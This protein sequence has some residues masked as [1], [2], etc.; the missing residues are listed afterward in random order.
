MYLHCVLTLLALFDIPVS[1]CLQCFTCQNSNDPKSCTGQVECLLNNQ[2]CFVQTVHSGNEVLYNMGCQ[3]NQLCSSLRVDHSGIIGRS[4]QTRQ[5]N[6]CHECCSTDYCNEEQLC[7][8]REV[9]GNW[10]DWSTWSNCSVTYYYI[11]IQ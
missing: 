5:Q 11:G 2:S 7:A 8:H 3:N 9:H 4:V 1:E 10:S 6:R